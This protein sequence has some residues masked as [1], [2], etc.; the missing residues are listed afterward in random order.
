MLGIEERYQS[1]REN[2]TG[3]GEESRSSALYQRN[4][5]EGRGTF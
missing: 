1:Y 2:R 4:R 3:I 5:K